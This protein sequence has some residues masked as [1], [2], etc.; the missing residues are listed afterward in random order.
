[1]IGADVRLAPTKPQLIEKGGR[2]MARIDKERNAAGDAER[3]IRRLSSLIPSPDTKATIKVLRIA[4]RVA[5][6][7]KVGSDDSSGPVNGARDE[8]GLALASL[9]CELEKGPPRQETINRARRAWL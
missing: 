6:G 3:A 8:I 9:I 7:G 5:I 2:Q 4:R 1:M